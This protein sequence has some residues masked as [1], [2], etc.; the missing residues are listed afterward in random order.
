MKN[1]SIGFRLAAWYFLV[2][3]VALS[4]FGIAA[5]FAMLASVYHAVDDELRDRVRGVQQF[6]E[7][8]IASLSIPEIR[9]EFREHSVL[10][11]GG[12]LFQVCDQAG[13]WLYRSVPLENNSVPI[14]KPDSL[15]SP[16]FKTAQVEGHPL[17]FYSQAISITGRAYTVQVAAPM[18]EAFEALQQFRILLLLG[19]PLLLIAASFGGYW[20]SSRALAPFDEISHAAERISIQSLTE[21]LHVAQTGDQ[22]QRLSQTLNQMFSRLEAAVKRMTQFT[23]DASHELRA[24]VALIRTTAEIAVMRGRSP[25]EYRDAL[26]DILGEAE[27][28]SQVIDSLLLLARTD[29]G[30]ERIETIALDARTVVREAAEQGEKLAQNHKV[31]FE[32]EIPGTA[33]PIRA[34]S[35][36]LRRALLILLDNAVKYTSNGGLVRLKLAP[37][38]G[39]AVASVSDT[40]IGIKQ[41]DLPYI[42]DRFWRADKARS[43][44]RE[45]AGLG[46]SIAKWL[47]EAQGGAISVTSDPGKGSTFSI[48]IALDT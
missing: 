48:R 28:M 6:M 26:T 44:E 1:R 15:T 40:G 7:R 32:A 14:E 17:R 31:V 33:V 12:D 36:A 9:D 11:P 2:F 25:S 27:R 16:Q 3:A 13:A 35:D 43:R 29:S 24:P 8:Q 46:L 47:I 37:V 41:E 30:T 10:G 21:R 5:W 19:V 4:I 34:D 42:F 22:L 23:A 39:F 45:G 20:I 38:E 18:H